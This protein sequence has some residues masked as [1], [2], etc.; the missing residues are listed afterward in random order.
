MPQ[1]VKP[2]QRFKTKIEELEA[3]IEMYR[4]LALN[5]TTQ[6]PNVELRYQTASENEFCMLRAPFKFPSQPQVKDKVNCLI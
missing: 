3:K 5:Q 2:T 6:T 1:E 4:I